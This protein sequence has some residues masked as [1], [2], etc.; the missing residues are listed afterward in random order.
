MNKFVAFAIVTDKIGN[1]H[2]INLNMIVEIE[3]MADNDHRVKTVRCGADEVILLS[4]EEMQKLYKA[5]AD[6]S[7]TPVV[8][9]NVH[10]SDHAPTSLAF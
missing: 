9:V 7:Q 5:I 4:N 8:N 1:Q 2:I 3:R 10:D 6:A